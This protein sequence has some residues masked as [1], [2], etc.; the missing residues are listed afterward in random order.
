MKKILKAFILCLALVSLG[1]CGREGT[2]GKDKPI[3]DL[4]AAKNA[5]Q[6]YDY[7]FYQTFDTSI[8]YI[9]YKATKEEFDEESKFVEEEFTRLHKLYDN[10]NSY[11]DIVSIKEVNDMAGKGPVKVDKDLFNLVKFAIDNYEKT[12]GK[13]NIA[14]GRTIKL[15]TDARNANHPSKSLGVEEHEI[16]DE[17]KVLPSPEEIKESGMH[18]DI[19]NIVLDEKN[20]TIEIKDPDML[21][22]LGAVGKGYA[23]EIVA[24]KLIDRGVKHASINAGGNVRSIG[25]PGDG[26]VKWGVGIQNPENKSK[27]FLEVL[28]TGPVS[29]V[30][31]GDY[32]RYFEKDGVRYHHII[33]P[34]TL[35]PGGDYSS[36]SILTENSG[37]A[38]YLSTVMFLS[39]K[40]EAEEILKNY[41][42][43]GVLWYSKKEG[44]SSNEYMKQF[45]KS[46]NAKSQ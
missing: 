24:Q 33:D 6:R 41:P 11:D 43:V 10:F 18:M 28:F 37:L 45:M 1:A 13:V 9:S 17:D 32:Q 44:K 7:S 38:D 23:T 25:T 3:K 16:D 8:T 2:A 15:W 35:Y 12:H 42:E 4:E 27:D 26:R 30:T 21:I 39:T 29:V 5:L 19:K 14:M 22:D 46:E 31:S 20:Q 36:V 34:K 40:E